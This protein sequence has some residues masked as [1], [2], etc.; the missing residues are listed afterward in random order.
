MATNVTI[1]GGKKLEQVLNK[2]SKTKQKV[3]GYDVGFFKSSEH[4]TKK[5]K[6]GMTIVPTAAIAVYN[7]FGSPSKNIPE[8]PFFRN[9]NKKAEKRIIHF[10]KNKLTIA[11]SF[12]LTEV[13]VRQIASVHQGEVQDS[14][15]KLRDPPNAPSTVKK[16]KSS[17]PLID[18]G[19]MRQ[20]VTY[21]IIE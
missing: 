8:R 21:E 17:N 10:L 9:G 5:I 6:G 11:E 13:M 15:T 18:T 4:V 14:I 2:F 16:K 1:S 12:I 20:A 19:Q 7:E 3:K